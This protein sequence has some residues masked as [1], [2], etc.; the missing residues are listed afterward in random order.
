M[1]NTSLISVSLLLSLVA[2]CGSKNEIKSKTQSQHAGI[3]GSESPVRSEG[4][5]QAASQLS[6]VAQELSAALQPHQSSA[7]G[8]WVCSGSNMF[9]INSEKIPVRF[10][11]V[12]MGQK[13]Y[14]ADGTH[15][16]GKVARDALIVEVQSLNETILNVNSI[17]LPTGSVSRMV[18]GTNEQEVLAQSVRTEYNGQVVVAEG[19]LLE[20]VWVDRADVL[21][22]VLKIKKNSN[23]QIEKFSFSISRLPQKGGFWPDFAG[24]VDSKFHFS[25]VECELNRS[26]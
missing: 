3:A 8:R 15:A 1:K 11:K 20:A 4:E 6:H 25:G 14:Q 18:P 23:N 17:A 24:I 7:E 21:Q 16:P 2:S 22:S 26:F 5:H 10:R 12:A 19:F 9:G 13:N